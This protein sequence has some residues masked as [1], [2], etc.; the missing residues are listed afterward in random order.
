MDRSK[1]EEYFRTILW[2]YDTQ[3]GLPPSDRMAL[4]QSFPLFLEL[5]IKLAGGTDRHKTLVEFIGALTKFDTEIA[6]Q[7]YREF[8]TITD[9]DELQT[10]MRGK[11][12]EAGITEEELA[13]SEVFVRH[14]PHLASW[15]SSRGKL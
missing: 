9:R 5:Q 4:R 11:Y 7:N 3:L 10:W 14:Q 13:A 15:L 6:L 8:V 12:L 1:V 2:I